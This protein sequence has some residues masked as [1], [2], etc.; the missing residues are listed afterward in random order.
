MRIGELSRQTGVSVRS[1]RYYESA[2]LIQ[3]VRQANGYR[4]FDPSTV[5]RVQHIHGLLANGCTLEEAALL[6]PCY[7]TQPGAAPLCL[8]ARER[9][10]AKLVEID[11]RIQ[12]MSELR[13]RIL[14]HI[15]AGESYDH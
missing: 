8:A 4:E 5:E 9:Y 14:A 6:L 13:E 7:E 1:L 15:K 12:V 3:S 2:G 10:A 11:R